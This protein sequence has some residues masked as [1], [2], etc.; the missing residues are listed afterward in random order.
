MAA[1]SLRVRLTEGTPDGVGVTTLASGQCACPAG[2]YTGS[3]GQ[4]SSC[5]ACE[6]GKYQGSTGTT[7]CVEVLKGDY[8]C[9]SGDS[10]GTGETSAATASCD[11]P[12]GKYTGSDGQ[13]SCTDCEEGKYQGSTGTT[14]CTA[15]QQGYFASISDTAAAS[16]ATGETQ[17]AAVT[18]TRAM[19]LRARGASG[20]VRVGKATTLASGQCAC[21]AGKYTGSVGQ[22]SCT[23]ARKAS[24]RKHR[25]DGVHG[26]PARV[27]RVHQRHGND[28]CSHRRDPG[29]CWLLRVRCR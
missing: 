20:D 18:P 14:V 17:V 16:A 21:P 8:A 24:T 3:V 4:T 5:T 7:V 28:L 27:L 2:M 10:D 11:C 19:P 26:G 29:G 9:L 12:A 23:A 1:G 13:T 22:T 6:S 25:H 15:A